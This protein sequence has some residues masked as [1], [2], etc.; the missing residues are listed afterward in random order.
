MVETTSQTTTTESVVT[1]PIETEAT[2]R[3][4]IPPKTTKAKKGTTGVT[5][6]YRAPEPPLQG[7][8][9]K[10]YYAEDPY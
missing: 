1:Q 2:P 5:K 8:D 10:D 3:P 9:I 7:V 6:G 4:Q